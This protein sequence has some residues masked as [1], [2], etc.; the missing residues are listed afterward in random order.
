MA[1]R[2]KNTK[3]DRYDL[4]MIVLFTTLIIFGYP[5]VMLP[6]YHAYQSIMS[7]LLFCWGFYVNRHR[8][9]AISPIF[10]FA[11]IQ[12][13]STLY[14]G[15]PMLRLLQSITSSLML[16][17]I[18]LIT[19]YYISGKSL[20][21][22]N[23][24]LKKI[25]FFY[26]AINAFSLISIPPGSEVEYLI[27]TKFRTSYM[28]WLL[29]V[30]IMY[31]GRI[32]SKNL[33]PKLIL[34]LVIS[35]LL[36]LHIEAGVGLVGLLIISVLYLLERK[37]LIDGLLKPRRIPLYV[38]ISFVVFKGI[39]FV[40]TLDIF[41]FIIQNVLGRN[42][43]LTGRLPIYLVVDD[44]FR[45]S[46]VIGHGFRNNMV[47]NVV[48]WG[49]AQNGIYEILI[50]LG[51]IGLVAF[52]ICIFK[53][54]AKKEMDKNVFELLKPHMVMIIA[55]T[56]AA[57]VEISFNIFFFLSL[58]AIYGVTCKHAMLAKKGTFDEHE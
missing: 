26:V 14:N 53:V 43:T 6:I 46:P 50:N 34:Y 8:I 2:F 22:Y 35:F 25:V 47:T 16:C 56:I 7:G 28:H 39:E 20:S 51:L 33:K 4:S 52:A 11:L 36:L 5:I 13:I 54:T 48:G 37:D 1:V 55:L 29:L 17:N 58:A 40:I 44:I 45:L 38:A 10:L 18:F 15:L 19:F 12:P 49:N 31:S 32:S 30:L 23:E 3:F 21:E 24:I 27:G 57:V 42:L 41:A 9:M